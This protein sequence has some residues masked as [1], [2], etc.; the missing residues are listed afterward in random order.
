MSEA[1]AGMNENARE[2]KNRLILTPLAHSTEEAGSYEILRTP[3][4]SAIHGAGGQ[5]LSN[6]DAATPVAASLKEVKQ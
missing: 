5:A 3:F 6:H 2:A 4:A 1:I